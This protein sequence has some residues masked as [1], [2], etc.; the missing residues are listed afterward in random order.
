MSWCSGP[1]KVSGFVLTLGWCP[2]PPCCLVLLVGF[3]WKSL[4][5]IHQS[6]P[7]PSVRT[8][9]P[10]VAAPHP[11]V[12]NTHKALSLGRGRVW[13]LS[14][15]LLGSL[16]PWKAILGTSGP[17]TLYS[18]WCSLGLSAWFASVPELQI[19]S[20][21]QP[22]L[23]LIS[24]NLLE[25]S[26]VSFHRTHCWLTVISYLSLVGCKLPVHLCTPVFSIVAD[27]S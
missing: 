4:A 21:H 5:G 24:W 17:D 1:Y 18:N 16:G 12:Y 7:G 27:I 22:L 9:L 15:Q 19:E 20:Q 13:L 10:S 26:V 2:Y 6:S 23:C 8:T 14:S 3:C 11:Q 25:G